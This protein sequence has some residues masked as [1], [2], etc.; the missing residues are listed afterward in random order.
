M[1]SEEIVR[2]ILI[3][4][5]PTIMLA[6]TFISFSMVDLYKSLTRKKRK[7]IDWWSGRED[8]KENG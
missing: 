7:R 6:A 5:V 8:E 3:Y 2:E 4:F 1:T